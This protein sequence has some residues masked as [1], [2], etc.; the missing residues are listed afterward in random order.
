MIAKKVS[1]K[2]DYKSLQYFNTCV[3]WSLLIKLNQLPNHLRSCIDLLKWLIPILQWE[4]S[5]YEK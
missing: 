5:N 1:S 3:T 4:V 2:L